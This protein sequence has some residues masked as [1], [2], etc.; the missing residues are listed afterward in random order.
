[1]LT[2]VFGLLLGA[3]L[4]DEPITP[5][6]VIALVAVAAGIWL[7]N[8]PANTETSTRRRGGRG[9][10]Q[11]SGLKIAVPLRDPHAGSNPVFLRVPP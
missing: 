7:V 5:R 10:P 9:G 2:P 6:L 4:L 11:R 8:R 3:L 1:M